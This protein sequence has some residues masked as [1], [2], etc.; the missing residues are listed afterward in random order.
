MSYVLYW[1]VMLPITLG[2]FYSPQTTP[3]S[4]FCIS[5]HIFVT[6][7]HRY[8]IFGQVAS[9][10]L[11]MIN[12]PWKRH[13]HVMLPVLIFSPH[14]ISM[15]QLKLQTSSSWSRD[16]NYP[17]VGMV[18]F[19]WPLEILGNKWYLEN[20]ARHIVTIEIGN[21]VW[22]IKWHKYQWPWVSSKVTFIVTTDKV[23]WAISVHLQSFLFVLIYDDNRFTALLDF[24][25][26]CPGE[27]V[28]ER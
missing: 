22:P 2:D 1:M 28:P 8:F 18:R 24:V 13:G 19:T 20:G 4:T 21:H 5:F 23:R 16:D 3:I 11:E 17:L 12:H 6:G 10:S 26:G 14:K 15:D 9:P 7:K 25:R 27:P